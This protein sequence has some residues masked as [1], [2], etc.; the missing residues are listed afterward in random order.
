MNRIFTSYP[1]RWGVLCLALPLGALAQSSADDWLQTSKDRPF[2]WVVGM[3]V[4]NS[5]SY[6]GSDRRSTG[7][8]PMLGVNVGRYTLS[9]GGGGSLLNFDL[10]RKESAGFSARLVDN[11]QWRLGA[12]LSLGGGR[13]SGDDP[14]LQGLPEVRRSLRGRLTLLYRFD[15]ALHL[16]SVL[17]TDLLGRGG[18]STWENSLNYGLR[19]AERS[20][21]TLG[22][23][24]TL[25]DATFMR[26]YL[27]VP[28]SAA[29]V[30][31]ALPAYRPG[32]G[33]HSLHAGV[34]LKTALTRH[35]LGVAGLGYSSL[36]GDARRSPLALEPSGYSVSLGLA[37]RY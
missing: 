27:G 10:L 12:G 32:A 25:A 14:M 15:E 8:K 7:A 16:R 22:V 20:V 37:Y 23:G 6:Q 11:E 3:A 36:Q 1:L 31:T 29:G 4:N 19:V 5:A 30:T 18:G 34:E 24:L 9:T 13:D 35:W 2:T 17:S 21:L 33:L 28:A 26:S